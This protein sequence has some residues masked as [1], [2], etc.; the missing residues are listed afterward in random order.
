M[1]DRRKSGMRLNDRQTDGYILVS[2]LVV[3]AVAAGLVSSILLLGR[4]SIDSLETTG[5]EIRE[6]ALLDSATAIVGFELTQLK[7]PWREVDGQQ[8]RLDGGEV[9]VRV[10]STEGKVD[11]NAS[12]KTLLAAAYRAAGLSRLVPEE[13]A[14][15]VIDWRDGDD[16]PRR[17]GAETSASLDAGASTRP[18]NGDFRSLADLSSVLGV[19]PA[20]LEQLRPFVTVF[21][22]NGRISPLLASEALL[23]QLPGVTA[24]SMKDIAA[25][26]RA[27]ENGIA[28]LAN[29]LLVQSALI[30]LT[31]PQTFDV[32]ITVNTGLER[33][34]RRANLV[35]SADPNNL[36]PFRTLFWAWSSSP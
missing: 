17:L 18:R 8:L 14:D 15:R 11:L 22:P 25:A 9:L 1:G 23:A 30:T 12:G 6:K 27:G 28:D 4:S 19:E 34:Q 20:D 33:G 7:R 2:V 35:L 36:Q 29:L 5:K 24:Q 10:E 21:N 3:I 32:T 16:E 26:R 13:F 31:P